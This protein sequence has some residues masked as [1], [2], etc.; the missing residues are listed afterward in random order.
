MMWNTIPFLGVAEELM[1]IEKEKLSPEE[2]QL[3][4]L[5]SVLLEQY[6]D[7]NFPSPKRTRERCWF[8]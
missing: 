2:G 4:E 8:T 7:N 6:E 5:L 1:K 3:L